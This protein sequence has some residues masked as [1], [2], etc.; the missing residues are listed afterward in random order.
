ME[1]F[2]EKGRTRRDGA[3]FN[4]LGLFLSVGFPIVFHFSTAANEL[5]TGNGDHRWRWFSKNG[6]QI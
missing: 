4:G 5:Q 6:A 1:K 3:V 2:V